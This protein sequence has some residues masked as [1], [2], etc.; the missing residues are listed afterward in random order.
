MYEWEPFFTLRVT[1]TPDPA[2]VL[3][4]LSKWFWFVTL[5]KEIMRGC[6]LSCLCYRPYLA[7]YPY[8]LLHF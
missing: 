5:W 8:M 1:V 6:I 2:N 4:A 3:E 7:C